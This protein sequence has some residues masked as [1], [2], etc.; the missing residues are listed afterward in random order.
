MDVMNT[1]NI[2]PLPPSIYH[3]R[4]EQSYCAVHAVNNIAQYKMASVEEFQE[5]AA[6]LEATEASL[7]YNDSSEGSFRGAN[8]DVHGDFSIQVITQVLANHEYSINQLDRR[9]HGRLVEILETQIDGLI[10]NTGNHWFA[11]KKI[12]DS[13]YNLDSTAQRPKR[14][15]NLDGVVA[16][17]HR[18]RDACVFICK[19]RNGLDTK[20]E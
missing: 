7:R 20:G 2:L 4:Q 17:I 18:K 12:G 10:I 15:E 9:E 14:F 16:F 19:Y 1:T 6:I 3:E 8:Q 5:V 13:Y 11:I